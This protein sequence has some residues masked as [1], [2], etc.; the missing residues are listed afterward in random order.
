MFSALAGGFLGLALVK[1]GNPSILDHLITAPTTLLE[2]IFQPWPFSWALGGLGVVLMAAWTVMR[3]R[4]ATM[5]WA[6]WLPLAWFGWQLVAAFF[7][8]EPRLT[9]S[10]LPHFGG[11]VVSFYL[12]LLALAR[13]RWMKGFWIGLLIGF[14]IMAW[15]GI[16]QHYGGLEATRRAVYA[17]PDWEQMPPE[18]LKRIGSQRIFATLLYPNALAGALLLLTPALG[19]ATWR[20]TAGRNPR[21][22]LVLTALLAWAGLAC[23][24]WSGSKAGWL[25]ALTMGSVV[26]FRLELGRRIRLLL[27]LAVAIGGLAG[28]A[29]KFSGYFARG[30]TS[31][32][33]RFDYWSAA[34]KTFQAHPWVGSGPGT[35]AESYRRLK[36]PEAEMAKLTHNDYL[37]QA[38]D[39]GWPGAL[40]YTAFVVTSLVWLR[41]RCWD[42]G[43][44]FAVWLGLVGWGLQSFVEFGL[45]LPAIG[46]TAFWLLGWLWGLAL[47]GNRID[48]GHRTP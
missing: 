1:F 35:F 30:A 8:S 33:A 42:D 25:I 39:S 40:A 41:R 26:L 13:V 15:M 11:V 7:T 2:V 16:D 44:R 32:S 14:A 38:S 10:V 4:P 28:F 29:L 20:L 34:G 22:Q 36:P 31:V 45:Y 12:G 24:V 46:W 37:Q 6:V 27:L 23:L 3:W 17:Q 19:V 48:N 18:F 43:L 5:H 21:I 47:A 9:R